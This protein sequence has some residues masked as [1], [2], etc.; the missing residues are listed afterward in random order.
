MR[1]LTRYAAA[2]LVILAGGM[3]RYADAD[4]QAATGGAPVS[5]IDTRYEDASMRPQDDTYRYLNG[6]WLDEFQIPADKGR[7]SSFDA[8][9]DR[10]QDQLHVI[11]DDLARNPGGG[12][13][14]AGAGDADARKLADLY[15]S[16]MD[17]AR[18][19][20]QRYTPIVSTFAAI[21]AL[22]SKREIPAWIARC[23]RTGIDAPYDVGIEP[24]AKDS[25]RYAVSIAQSGLG[26][27]DR[28]YYLKDD[29]KFK[30]IRAKYLAHIEKMLG[31]VGDKD[32]ARS[33]RDIL[34]LESAMAQLQ[35][36][37]VE[38]RNPA[39]TYNKFAFAA[40]ASLTPRYD[41]HPYL[42]GI[43]IADKVDYVI[44]RQPSY[45]GG[46]A[47]LIERTPLSVWREYFQWHALAAAAPY[48][49]KAFVEERFAFTGTV[50]RGI[51]EN[52]P[53]WKRG[54]ALLDYS[55]GEALGRLYVARYFPPQNKERMQALVQNLLRAYDR[56]IDSLEW[57]S[58]ETKRGAHAKLAK[59]ITKIGYP[60]KWR[61][62]TALKVLREDLWGNVVRATAFE[63]QRQIDKLGRPIDRNEWLMTP[64]TVNAYYEP[65]MNEIVFPAAI[66]QPPFFN[67]EADDAV[68]Y[69]AIGAVIG[70]E[71]SHGF[72]DQGSQYDADGNLRD[73][74]APADHE[75][76]KAQTQALVAQYDAYE[77]VPGF[78]VN[79]QLTL[80]E[81][82]ADNAGL[83][84][85]Y[86]A[87]QLSLD[88][89]PAPVIDGLTG[90]QRFYLGWVQV[91]RG[92]AREQESVQR[93]KVDPHS[94]TEV[95]G[96]A[97]LRNQPGFYTA[98]GVGPGDKMYLP[99]EQRATIW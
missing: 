87:Y 22:K 32:S 93:I 97:A 31:M 3:G 27:P 10:T 30:D 82:I 49:S 12:S 88:G 28:D 26:L 5:G 76:F 58:A 18:L 96:K 79:G 9:I 15:A 21:R 95:R 83:A 4:A 85:A 69:G 91:Y 71:I 54:L 37:R 50:L 23:N 24:D 64:Q 77:P 94:P 74:F 14:A 52:R 38:N 55:M 29:D 99:P 6:K 44:V 35:W 2:T 68:N 81:N 89:R 53:R 34:K 70:H 19:E 67:V 42:A 84:I 78:H 59:L 51:P 1:R 13:N 33:A 56:D 17:E 8:L 40:L 92:K 73:W 62:Y 61:D 80:G 63:Y 72:D 43:R 90:E 66:L 48:L 36:T 41:W 16:F 25:S 60:D 98:F 47:E 20:T 75:K 11:V 46:L 86:K 65:L 57:M 39:K 7:Y 45:I